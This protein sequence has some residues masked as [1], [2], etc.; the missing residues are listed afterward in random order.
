MKRKIIVTLLMS[1]T[2]MA[3][4]DDKTA[5]QYLTAA[6]NFEQQ[7]EL[8]SAII[9]YKNVLKLEPNNLTARLNLGNIYLNDNELLAAK[10]ELKLAMRITDG[11]RDAIVPYATVLSYLNEHEELLDLPLLAASLSSDKMVKAYYLRGQSYIALEDNEK[12]IEEYTNATSLDRSDPYGMLSQAVVS[13]L[14]ADKQQAKVQIKQLL[15]T[16]P[17]MPEAVLF[18]GIMTQAEED[19]ETAIE[20]YRHYLTIEQYK[21]DYVKLLLAET[22]LNIN[23]VEASLAIL[24][25][26]LERFPLQPM[27]SLMMAKI[28]FD[29]EN[30]TESLDFAKATLNRTP[31]H[32]MANLLAGMSAFRLS[33][34][35]ESYKRLNRIEKKLAGRTLPIIMLAINNIKLGNIVHASKLLKLAGTIDEKNVDLFLFAANEFK[36]AQDYR[37]TLTILEEAEKVQPQRSKIKLAKGEALL[38][39]NDQS[40]LIELEKIVFDRNFTST[41]SP[42]LTTQYIRLGRVNELDALALRLKKGLADKHD[43]WIMAGIAAINKKD[44]SQA[45]LEFSHIL[46][47]N[48][49]SVGALLNLAKLKAQEK[50]YDQSLSFIDRA[51]A[52]AADN[53][54]LLSTKAKV[55]FLK[56]ND[57]AKAREVFKSAYQGTHQSEELVVERAVIYASEGK[58][59]E[60]IKLLEEIQ[61]RPELS[62]KYWNT[63]GDLLAKTGS[64]GEALKV[65]EKWAS[66]NPQSPIPML[67]QIAMTERMKIYDQGLLVIG[68]AQDK[69]AYLKKLQLLEVNFLILNNQLAKAR[70]AFSLLNKID[71]SSSDYSTIAGELAFKEKNYHGAILKLTPVYQDKPS[72][73]IA[74]SIAASYLMTKQHKVAIDFLESHLKSNPKHSVLYTHLASAYSASGDKR[75]TEVYEKLLAQYPE[76]A[77][78]L[79]NMAWHLLMIDDFDNALKYAQKALT[80]NAENAQILDTHGMILLKLSKYKQAEQ[81]LQKALLLEPNDIDITLHNAELY[82]LMG[83][84]AKSKRLLNAV[85]PDL[86]E[87]QEKRT[88]LLSRI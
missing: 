55:I 54:T 45:E 7:G 19:F 49:E 59:L 20:Q 75:A 69:F 32:Y 30:F 11:R 52:L 73:R 38:R 46:K 50:E 84:K 48:P 16:Y 5:E 70:K 63:L 2:L 78:V 67:K 10:K 15:D 62:E 33:D 61:Q 51:L 68:Q 13:H 57:S 80:I 77:V 86:P 24:Q 74:T 47:G 21:V 14:K 37:T 12:A 44:Y 4:G 8:N 65:F 60:G 85:S 66:I 31:K 79:N 34:F 3:C 1:L 25:D 76:N 23:D 72:L 41:V 56:T 88:E 26:V 22:L 28:E 87:Q 82:L 58:P 64:E 27:A 43:G 83:N 71:F 53:Y 6:V 40:G 9:E 29:R 17:N 18:Y 36:A 81:S 39:L 42:I 35:D